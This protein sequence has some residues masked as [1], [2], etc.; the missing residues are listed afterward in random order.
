MKILKLALFTLCLSTSTFCG[1]SLAQDPTYRI[2]FVG[3]DKEMAQNLRESLTL[4]DATA[5]VPEFIAAAK[6][7]ITTSLQAYGYYSPQMDIQASKTEKGITAVA[8]VQLGTPIRVQSIDF[9]LLGPGMNDFALSQLRAA[10]TLHQGDIFVHEKYE[11]NKKALLSQVI[12]AGYLSAFF[13]QHQVEVDI[14][15]K[16]AQ[17]HLTLETGPRHFFGQVQ[18]SDTALSQDLLV[19]YLPFQPGEIYSPE[20]VLIL[21]SR[22]NQS[23]YFSAVN[24]RALTEEHNTSV[25]IQVELTDAKPNQYTIGAGY[26]TD[27][28]PRGKVGWTRRRLN[29]AGHRL[30]SNAQISEIYRKFNVDYIIPGRHPDTDHFKINGGFYD[31]EYSEKPT[32]IYETGI[33]E[34]R[35]IQHWQRRLSL[36][37]HHERFGAYITNQGLESHLVLPSM[38]F[39]HT[40]RDNPLTP[41]HGRRFEITMRGSIDALFSDTTFFQAYTQFR[42]LHALNDTTK[43]LFRTEWGFTIPDDSVKLPLSQRFF[44]GGDL[45]LRGFG[46]RSLPSEIDKDGNYLPVGGAYLGIASLELSKKVKHPIGVFTFI[47]AGNAFRRFFDEIEVGTGVGVE[48]QTRIGPIK[49]A[50]AKPLTKSLDAWRIHAMFGPEI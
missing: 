27:T 32:Q 48:W 1:L 18:F 44:A 15:N 5:S 23:N 16:T 45:S 11:Q 2:D 42:W 9:Q 47:D 35:E 41:T 10:L 26:G 39:I 7:D 37:Y 49:I 24:V 17:I 13:S 50:L 28:G 31:D 12:Q 33:I 21:Q 20:K 34:E 40:V 22:L 3:V 14:D 46:Y 6:Q 19:R 25:P 36:F 30:T 43:V 38:T 29:S 8:H 4:D